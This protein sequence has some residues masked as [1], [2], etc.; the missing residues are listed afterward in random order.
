MSFITSK[1]NNLKDQI[2][3][4]TNIKKEVGDNEIDSIEEQ[5]IILMEESEVKTEML[6][7]L[8]IK[9]EDLKDYKLMKLYY[10]MAISRNHVKAMCILGKY[11]QYVE[12][13]YDLMKK[14]YG[15]VMEKGVNIFLANNLGDYYLDIEKNYP[16]YI[17]LQEH[18]I[19]GGNTDIIFN[20]ALFYHKRQVDLDLAIKYY[21]MAISI[22]NHESSM[23]NLGYIYAY[24]KINWE[25]AEKY[26]ELAIEIHKSVKAMYALGHHYEEEKDYNKMKLYYEMAEHIGN[27]LPSLISLAMYYKHI[28]R[29]VQSM[30]IYFFKAIAKGSGIA[31]NNYG[32]YFESIG[33]LETAKKYYLDAVEN[34]CP[35]GYYS[36][37]YL[38]EFEEKNYPEAK[39]YYE[40]AVE[41]G[42]T[43]AYYY[44]GNFYDEVENNKEKA[45]EYF[46]LVV[47]NNYEVPEDI[48][49][50]EI[51]SQ[52]ENKN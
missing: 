19:Q 5:E 38:Y 27:Y 50:Q 35:H 3:N 14:Y 40:L 12:K 36:L 30:E 17:E 32:D 11:Y 8:G 15:M 1:I 46:K 42:V 9:Y 25:L 43:E 48:N 41:H 51:I 28:E 24:E 33:Q 16:K 31:M 7:E 6:Y 10:K 52:L 23:I 13:D 37:G 47:S 22:D 26:F 4:L 49:I 2:I 45:L 34:N 21:T 29:D 20:L 39:K 44:L 18:A